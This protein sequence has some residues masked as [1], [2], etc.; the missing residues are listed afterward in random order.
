MPGPLSIK[1]TVSCS[2]LSNLN[3][4]GVTAMKNLFGIHDDLDG[5]DSSPENT[6]FILE[7]ITLLS[8]KL[9]DDAYLATDTRESLYQVS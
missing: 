2:S 1:L 3:L 6:G 8:S 7:M 9:N 5:T 4:N